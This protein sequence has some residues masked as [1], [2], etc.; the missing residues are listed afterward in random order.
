[1]HGF[2]IAVSSSY[3]TLPSHTKFFYNR[4]LLLHCTVIQ[5]FVLQAAPFTLLSHTKFSIADSST[6]TVQ[7]YTVLYIRQLSVHC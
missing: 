5:V 4:Q 3:C 2:T 1:M 7:S 6:K